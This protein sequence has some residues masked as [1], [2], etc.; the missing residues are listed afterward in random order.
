MA[1]LTNLAV[2]SQIVTTG[3]IPI[4]YQPD[5]AVVVDAVSA[6]VAAGARAVEFTNRG[7]GAY[8][9]FAAALGRLRNEAPTAMVGV[10]SIVDTATAALYIGEG[11]SFVVGPYFRPEVAALCLS[12]GVVYIPGAATPG[13]IARAEAHGATMV[14]VFPARVLGPGFVRD[15]LGPSPHSRLVPT[16]GVPATRQAVSEWITAGAI[17]VGIGTQLVP[18]H[19]TSPSDLG[20]L[21]DRVAKV[22]GWIAEARPSAIHPLPAK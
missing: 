21:S 16:G 2:E 3:L 18:S 13:E 9:V 8:R 20:T 15:V 14:K 5:P 11:A 10:G 6:C 4:F 1:P 17:A 19:P 12:R 22:L 7:E